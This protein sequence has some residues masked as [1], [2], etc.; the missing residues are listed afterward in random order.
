MRSTR[1][2][3]RGFLKRSA[4]AGASLSLPV[5]LP[6]HVFAAPGRPG[7]N[8]KI[9]CGLI[10]CG[11][12]GLSIAPK[13]TAAVADADK[14]H[15]DRAV[16]KYGEKCEGFSDYR[17]LLERKDLDCVFIGA[18]D[19]W[20]ALMT[21]H[22]CQ[23]GK[24]VYCEKPACNTIPEGKAMIAAAKK[25]E[26]VVQIGSQGRSTAGGFFACQYIRNGMLGKVSKVTC[27]H[28]PNPEGG[29]PN[30][31]ATP[32]A[33][34]DWDAWLGPAKERSYNPAYHPGS[35]RWF[36]D[37]G[38]GNIRDRGAHIMSVLCW[39]MNAE[40]AMPV[41]VECTATK[42]KEGALYDVPPRMDVTYEFKNPDWTLTWSQ[43]GVKEGKGQYGAKY[44]GD[45]DTLVVNG[46]DGGTDTEE[47]AMK[48]QPPADGVKVFRSPGHHENFFQCMRSREKP[49]MWVEYG[50]HVA[51]LNNLGNA[52]YL[53][54]KKI[55]WDP[56]KEKTDDDKANAFLFR[57]SRGKY[58]FPDPI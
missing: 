12:R 54:G 46:G 51:A 19:H 1:T 28:P 39:C 22:A 58:K 48:Y 41:T 2:S 26:R 47:K 20:H 23:A 3:R 45:K 43:P 9:L 13:D 53:A 8:D 55:T 30:K 50:V 6:S 33:H 38:G 32:P 16:K 14:N 56:A 7:P 44:W 40:E 57:E 18:P 49:I 31:N 5:L 11:G 37:L 52:A 34:L 15:V 10:G 42:P 36:L 21:V 35:F 17:K 25:Y 27:W 24:D 4:A 29:D